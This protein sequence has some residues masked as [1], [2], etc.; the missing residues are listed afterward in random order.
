MSYTKESTVLPTEEATHRDLQEGGDAEQTTLSQQADAGEQVENAEPDTQSQ[1]GADDPHLP[2]GIRKGG[3]SRKLTEKGKAL[4]DDKVTHL[5]LSL[6]KMYR[7][8]KY[9]I[10]GL[11]RSIKNNDAADL[12]D[13]IVNAINTIQADIDNTYLEIRAISSPEPD[14]RRMNDTCQAFTS[15]ANKKTQHFCS[16]E[17]S[18]DIS[19][20]DAKSVFDSTVS[21]VSSAQTSKS[22]TSSKVSRHSSI[23]SIDAKQAAAEDAAT[24]EVIKIMNAQHQQKEEIERLEVEDQILKAEREAK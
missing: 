23:L 8:W 3:R 5:N 11:K 4:L 15:I 22:K 7:R 24:Q 12:I 21:S 18:E 9:H 14:I 19:W 16:G 1:V 20:P 13:V 2:M 10:N 6:S 17:D